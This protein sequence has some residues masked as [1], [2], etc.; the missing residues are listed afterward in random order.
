MT[1]LSKFFSSFNLLTYM[2]FIKKQNINEVAGLQWGNIYLPNIDD[3]ACL[4]YFLQIFII[5][6]LI[7]FSFYFYYKKKGSY[8]LREHWNSL[9]FFLERHDSNFILRLALSE[10]PRNPTLMEVLRRA[11]VIDSKR[12]SKLRAFTPSRHLSL[13]SQPASPAATTSSR[14]RSDGPFSGL[15][16]CVTGLSKGAFSHLIVACFLREYDLT[17]PFLIREKK[18]QRKIELLLW[19]L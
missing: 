13:A 6:Y 19:T 11:E 4:S 15:V 1:F 9:F 16:I 3:H 2:Y 7:S 12:C 8:T 14:F 17:F 18:R 5:F 10:S